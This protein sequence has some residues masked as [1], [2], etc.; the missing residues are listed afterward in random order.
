MAKKYNRTVINEV[1]FI[2]GLNVTMA[3]GN[4]GFNVKASQKIAKDQKALVGCRLATTNE[5][6]AK[7]YFDRLVKDAEGKGWIRSVASPRNA[8]SEIPAPPA[9]AAPKLVKK[10]AK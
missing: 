7:D 3:K 6:E 2:G 4:S 9:S 8:F 5:A 1:K 10:V